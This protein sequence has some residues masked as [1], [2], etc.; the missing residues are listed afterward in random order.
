MC[1][2]DTPLINLIVNVSGKELHFHNQ[3]MSSFDDVIEFIKSEGSLAQFITDDNTIF[4]ENDKQP[5]NQGHLMTAQESNTLNIVLSGLNIID[6][7]SQMH[8]KNLKRVFNA[9]YVDKT[10]N[11]R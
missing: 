8:R 5:L 2:V 6:T 1:K 9:N 4:L 10:W 7:G 11:E 3:C